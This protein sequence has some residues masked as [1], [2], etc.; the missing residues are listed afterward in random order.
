LAR[1]IKKEREGFAVSASGFEASVNALDAL[2]GEPLHQLLEAGRGVGKD[3]VAEFAALVDETDIE[4]EFGD[5]N[6]KCWFSHC[7]ELLV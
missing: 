1:L 5:V 6:A 7:S 4:L 3:F 2:L